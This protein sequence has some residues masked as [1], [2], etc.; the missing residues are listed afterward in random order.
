MLLISVLLLPAVFCQNDLDFWNVERRTRC[1][2]APL[3]V[4]WAQFMI[5]L[6]YYISLHAGEQSSSRNKEVQVIR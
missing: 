2:G 3:K 5:Q 1:N 4:E 6:F